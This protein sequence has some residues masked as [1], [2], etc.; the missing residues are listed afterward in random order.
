MNRFSSDNRQASHTTTHVKNVL[1]PHDSPRGVSSAHSNHDDGSGECRVNLFYSGWGF[2]LI[3]PKITV[4]IDDVAVGTGDYRHGF[5]I[6]ATIKPGRHT[7][8]VKALLVRETMQL[9][10]Q[11]A[12]RYRVR[13]DCENNG[14]AQDWWVKEVL[15]G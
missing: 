5:D 10:L 4:L 11:N 3:S 14:C 7:I 12:G 2:C 8:T 9:E 13:I 1:L 6:N 15:A